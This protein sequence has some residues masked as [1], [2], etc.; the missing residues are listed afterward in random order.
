MVELGQG[1]LASI[2]LN[3]PEK[4]KRSEFRACWRSCGAHSKEFESAAR[5][6]RGGAGRQ[7]QVLSAAAPT[8][9]R[10]T[11][12]NAAHRRRNSSPDPR[13]AAK[14]SAQLPVPVVARLHGA[15]IGAGLEIAAAC[16]LRVAAEGTQLRHAGGEARHPLG[17]RGGAAAAPDGRRARRLAG[18]HRRGDRRA[19]ARWSGAWSR[20]S[21]TAG[22]WSRGCWP[23]NP[24]GAADAEAAAAALGRGTARDLDRGE[25]LSGSLRAHR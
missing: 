22:I 9:P 5:S 24:R 21:A 2:F 20:N 8:S 7:R 19:D 15:V 23:M 12:L 6:A 11:A 16:D 17:G 1:R 10:W 25:H 14:R 18:A 4:S 13:G 3:R